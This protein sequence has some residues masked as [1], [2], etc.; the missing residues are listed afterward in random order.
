MDYRSSPLKT[1]LPYPFLND[2]KFINIMYLN[3][4]LS[5]ENEF[6]PRSHENSS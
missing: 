5:K 4:R 1:I 6:D 3:C 2:C